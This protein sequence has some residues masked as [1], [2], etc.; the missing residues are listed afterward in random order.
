MVEVLV[1]NYAMLTISN[2]FQAAIYVHELLHIPHTLGAL[3]TVPAHNSIVQGPL[4]A[5]AMR[6]TW[7]I[8]IS[9]DQLRAPDRSRHSKLCTQANISMLPYL[10]VARE[11]PQGK[12]AGMLLRYHG[13]NATY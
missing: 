7:E 5:Y 3:M 11:E 12:P 8:Y 2:H 4:S 1:C 6:L 13:C 9:W 10:L